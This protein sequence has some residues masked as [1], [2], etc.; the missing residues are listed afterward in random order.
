M[1]YRQDSHTKCHEAWRDRGAE[2]PGLVEARKDHDSERLSGSAPHAFTIVGNY[3]ESVGTW[4]KM[5]IE[6]RPARAGVHPVAIESN[7][8]KPELDRLRPA[9][10]QAGIVNLEV[11]LAGSQL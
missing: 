9:P 5:R 6:R 4:W 1:R 11:F 2:P 3:V 7:E 8:P 10:A